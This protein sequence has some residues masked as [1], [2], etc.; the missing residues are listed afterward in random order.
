LAKAVCF[1]QVPVAVGDDHY[2]EESLFG[3]SGL[4]KP[5]LLASETRVSILLKAINPSMRCCGA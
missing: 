3:I 5:C 4:D 1:G 2:T